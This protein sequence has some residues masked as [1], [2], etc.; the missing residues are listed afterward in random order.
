MMVDHTGTVR[1]V[2]EKEQVSLVHNVDPEAA[3]EDDAQPEIGDNKDDLVDHSL[4]RHYLREN[5]Y[6]LIYTAKATSSAFA[7]ALFLSLFQI[8]LPV[9]ALLDLIQFKDSK[10]P[11]QIPN[12]VSIEVRITAVMCLLLAIPLFWDL[13]DAIEKLQQGPLP[14]SEQHGDEIP[15]G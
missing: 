1:P 11:L 6:S 9:L 5:T 8:C 10:N 15:C 2:H 12:D 14:R 3:V 7:L 4:D 13:M